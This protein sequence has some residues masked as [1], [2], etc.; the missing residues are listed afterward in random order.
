[1]A[2]GKSPPLLCPNSHLRISTRLPRIYR[3]ESQARPK[4]WRQE[5]RCAACGRR[6]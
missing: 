6:A 5:R 2:L 4:R 1:M 3:S